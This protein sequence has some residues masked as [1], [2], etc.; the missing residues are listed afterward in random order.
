[1]LVSTAPDVG[2]SR[3]VNTLKTISSREIRK[4]FAEHLRSFYWKPVFGKRGYS[5]WWSQFGR[6]QS[7]H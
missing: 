3:L 2:I 1:M 4:E 6:A 5:C 7:I